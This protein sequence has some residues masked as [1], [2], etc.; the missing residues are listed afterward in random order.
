MLDR[1]DEAFAACRAGLLLGADFT[2]DQEPV[3]RLP[4]CHTYARRERLTRRQGRA[5]LGF[6]EAVDDLRCCELD[7]LRMGHVLGFSPWWRFE[8]LLTQDVSQVITCFGLSQPGR[9]RP[10]PSNG[11][12]EGACHDVRHGVDTKGLCRVDD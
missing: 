1:P 9:R 6:T 3:A 5:T 7:E 11:L 2:I 8:L 10:C 12:G 4:L